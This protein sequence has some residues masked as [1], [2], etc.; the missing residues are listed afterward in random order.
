[1]SRTE[2]VDDLGHTAGVDEHG[3]QNGLLGLYAVGQ[4]AQQQLLLFRCHRDRLHIWIKLDQE[5]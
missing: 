2:L 3:A 1:M 4:L 5:K